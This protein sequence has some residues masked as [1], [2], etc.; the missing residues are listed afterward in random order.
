MTTRDFIT[1]RF[2]LNTSRTSCSSVMSD[3]Q[4][5]IYSY[6][7]HYPLLF[8]LN[9][10]N[11]RNVRGYS[12]TTGRHILWSRDVDAIDIHAPA[13]YRLSDG[14]QPLIDSQTKYVQSLKSEMDAKVRKNTQVYEYLKA[15]YIKASVNLMEL[16]S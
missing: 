16:I 6:G 15:R 3:S 5:N 9:G 12:S 7:Y 10:K 11:I 1:A 14:I 13:G 2:Y 8:T 4:G